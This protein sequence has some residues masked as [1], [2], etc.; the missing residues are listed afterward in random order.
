MSR[1]LQTSPMIW[2]SG[3]RSGSFEV[4]S[5][6]WVPSG[7]TTYSSWSINARPLR[8]TPMSSS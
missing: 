8:M 6:N 4:E 7:R 2:P 3:L 1:A 5:H